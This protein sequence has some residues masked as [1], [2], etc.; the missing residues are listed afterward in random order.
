MAVGMSAVD[1]FAVVAVNGIVAIRSDRPT[2]E[3]PPNH[4]RRLAI[5]LLEA[6]QDA[7]RPEPTEWP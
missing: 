4:A 1:G 2:A 7:E 6:A 5:C 3:L